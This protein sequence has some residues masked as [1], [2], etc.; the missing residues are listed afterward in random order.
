MMRVSS[1]SSTMYKGRETAKYTTMK[2]RNL[3]YCWTTAAASFTS[4]GYAWI[5]PGGGGGGASS[6]TTTFLSRTAAA[7]LPPTGRRSIFGQTPEFMTINDREGPPPKFRLGYSKKSTLTTRLYSSS[8][9]N[10]N[11]NNNNKD[12]EGFLSKLGK[13]AQKFLPTSIFGSAEEKQALARKKEYRDQVSGGLDTL[14]KDAPLPL[15]MMGKMISPLLS[16]VAST[17]ADTMA[18]QQR[19][20]EG[21]LEEARDYL[22]GDPA[23]CQW[24]GEPI[25]LGTPFSQSSSSSSI[26]GLTQTRIELAMPIQGSKGVGTVRLLAT[27]EGISQIQLDVGGRRLDVSLTAKGRSSSSSSSIG[28][29]SSSRVNG[30]DNIIEAEVIEKETK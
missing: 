5:P 28:S 27:Q 4:V 29:S 17:L 19:T 12:D 11:N 3:W 23:V 25:Q 1:S 30:D 15:R 20:M 14:L 24:I 9:L 21:I 26:N 13:A 2:R 10:N 8:S 6:S 18:E 7:G 16:N 22:L